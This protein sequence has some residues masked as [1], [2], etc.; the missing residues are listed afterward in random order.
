M[1]VKDWEE[2]LRVGVVVVHGS[3]M[4]G[5]GLLEGFL[6]KMVDKHGKEE[7]FGVREN[8]KVVQR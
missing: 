3:K 4:E 2:N 8:Q 6:E 5:L 7:S 1:G